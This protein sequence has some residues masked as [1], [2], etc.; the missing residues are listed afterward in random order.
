MSC[1]VC[2]ARGE[3]R[4]EVSHGLLQA[5]IGVP[6]G[7]PARRWMF[8]R[9]YHAL[10]WHGHNCLVQTL[11]FTACMQL[12]THPCACACVSP[13]HAFWKCTFLE[14]NLLLSKVA[15]ELLLSLDRMLRIKTIILKIVGNRSHP[16]HRF[17]MLSSCLCHPQPLIL[18]NA[19]A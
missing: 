3:S 15:S 19:L 8:H 6:V 18:R 1:K 2:S 16:N 11:N 17:F 9:L 10:Q 5:F 7:P 12:F 4:W 14:Y 13:H